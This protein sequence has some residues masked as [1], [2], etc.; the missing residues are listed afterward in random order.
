MGRLEIAWYMVKTRALHTVHRGFLNFPNKTLSADTIRRKLFGGCDTGSDAMVVMMVAIETML[1]V[2][3]MI[4]VMVLGTPTQVP[5]HHDL[6]TLNVPYI[7]ITSGGPAGRPPASK[8]SNYVAVKCTN[9]NSPRQ[10]TLT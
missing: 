1:V 3:M 6:A 10:E 8:H 7:N 4:M 2:M 9:L 5:F